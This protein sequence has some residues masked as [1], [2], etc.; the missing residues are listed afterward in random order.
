MFRQLSK[1][2]MWK[3]RVKPSDLNA[4]IDRVNV[5]SK[6]TGSGGTVITTGPTGINI[7][8]GSTGLLTSGKI[9]EIQSTGTGDGIYN[10]YEQVIDKSDW[11]ETG[12]TD[13]LDDKNTTSIEVWN[14][15]ENIPESTYKEQLGLYD[16]LF[17]FTMTDDEGTSR[18][19]GLPISGSYV[20]MAQLTESA[21]ANSILTTSLTCN[22]IGNNGSE[23][24][25]GLGSAI[26]IWAKKADLGTDVN[27]NAVLPRLVDNDIIFVT[28]IQGK[29][30]WLTTPQASEDC[31]CS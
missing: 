27:W 22:L 11:D 6:I 10:C 12:G 5:L 16:R 9:Y 14:M 8:A 20:R 26:E 23:I 18:K 28:N 7:K 13:K 31:V 29:W 30:W 2:A 17:A 4:L 25:S 1:I 21:G 19:I 15:L 24:T 3:K